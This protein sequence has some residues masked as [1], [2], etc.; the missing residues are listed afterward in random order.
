MRILH[1]TQVA[2]VTQQIFFSNPFGIWIQPNYFST[3]ST[4]KH[5]AYEHKDN[6]GSL[7]FNKSD[8]ERAPSY[9]GEAMVD[10]KMKRVSVWFQKTKAGQEYL[11]MKFEDKV[12]TNQVP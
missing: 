4:T 10:G 2:Q 5:M 3:D 1:L 7:F 8:N 6:T 9:K 12:A 11:S